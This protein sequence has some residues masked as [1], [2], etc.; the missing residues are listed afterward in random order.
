MD[1]L[2]NS[3]IRE[4]LR[5]DWDIN[6]TLKEVANLNFSKMKKLESSSSKENSEI[7]GKR[8]I[9]V[10]YSNFSMTTP[11]ASA[12]Q[13]L[14]IKYSLRVGLPLILT[15]ILIFSKEQSDTYI[16]K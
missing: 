16:F 12:P 5:K 14:V 2:V 1:S 15:S 10:F 13:P 9:S 8:K 11:P 7:N 3:E 4:I 6:L